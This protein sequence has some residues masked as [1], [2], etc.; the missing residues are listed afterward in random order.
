MSD[1]S[2]WRELFSN[3]RYRSRIILILVCWLCCYPGLIYGVGAFI[4]VYMVD[5]G[6]SSHFVFGTFI[7]AY[8]ATFVAFQI[9]SRLG[10][11]LERRDTMFV[12]CIVFSL[13][14][15]VAYLYPEPYVMATCVVIGRICTTLVLFNLYNYTAVSFPTRIRSVAFAWTDGLGHLGAWAGVT[16]LGPL[17]QLGPNHLGWLLFITIPGALLPALLIR[18]FGIRQS[19]AVLEQVST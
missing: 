16:L 13:A 3:Q 14:W 8:A 1:K 9:N 18:G 12:L 2:A 5:H 6:V 7:A 11:G 19:H 10:E 17:Y 4:G 15:T